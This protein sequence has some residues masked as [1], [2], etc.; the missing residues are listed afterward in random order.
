MINSKEKYQNCVDK[1]LNSSVSD[2]CQYKFETELGAHLLGNQKYYRFRY[3]N[4]CTIEESCGMNSDNVEVIDWPFSAFMLPFGMDRE[5]AFKVL[6]F[7]MDFVESNYNFKECSEGKVR[8]LD[9]ILF[10][11]ELGFMKLGLVFPEDS[12]EVIDLFS[13]SGSYLLFKNSEGY[14]RYFQWYTEGVTFEEV[15]N[16]YRKINIDFSYFEVFN[17]DIKVR[18]RRLVKLR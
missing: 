16:I 13:V 8:L 11:E 9:K 17:A 12:D 2:D 10:F 14:S 6:S 5:D 7:L 1:L 3:V 15:C 4:Y 18:I